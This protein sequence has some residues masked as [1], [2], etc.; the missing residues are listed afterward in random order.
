MSDDVLIT[1]ASRKIEFFDNGGN[2]DGKIELDGSGNLN[3]TSAGSIAI[4]DITQ[5]IHIG[6]G[7][8]AV[9][10]VFDFTSSIYSVAGQDLTIGKSSLGNNDIIVDSPNW[11][12]TQGGVLDVANL[13]IATAQ[14]SDGQV[15]TST[16][17]GV[18]WED[19]AGGAVSA[20]ANGANNRVAT[21]SSADALNGEANM[22][23]NGNDLIVDTGSTTKIR[24]QGSNNYAATL[25]AIAQGAHLAMGDMDNAEDEWLKFGA[26]GGINNLDT[27]TRD[28]HLYGTNTTTGFYFDESTGLFGIGTTSP[29]HK[30]HVTGPPDDSGDY[31]I[32][33]DEGSDQYVALVNRHSSNRATAVFY[34]NIHADFTA[35]PMVT[36]LQ[37]LSLIHI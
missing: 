19:A 18:G 12:V 5:D 11:S 30:L 9:D 17:S 36:I 6:D 29:G 10:L 33:A 1:P 8:Q 24:T 3:I 34:R 26:F 7:T 37:D 22:T 32:Y 23:F 13:K 28:F 21:F 15:L 14:G 20:V 27:K 2:I 31:A 16:G 25:V 4:G 35:Q